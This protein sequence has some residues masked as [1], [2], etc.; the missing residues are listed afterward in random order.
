[1]GKVPELTFFKRR[2]TDDR[3]VKKCSISLIIRE[4]QI[5]I[6]MRYHLT[7]IKMATV[8]KEKRKKTKRQPTEWKKIFANGI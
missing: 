3:H 5:K 4:M 8:K 6:T 2:Q 1:M 7:P